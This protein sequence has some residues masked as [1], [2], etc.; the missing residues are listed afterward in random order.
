VLKPQ[1]LSQ[2]KYQIL[3]PPCGG[4]DAIGE[5]FAQFC[6]CGTSLLRGREVFLQSGGAAGRHGAADP[7]Q[8]PGTRVEDLGV[9]EIED[10]L[11]YPHM[12]SF[13]HR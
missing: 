9:F 13:G 12:A 6:L 3:G 7:D 8:F 10:L 5:S 2:A 4:D 1:L 11:L